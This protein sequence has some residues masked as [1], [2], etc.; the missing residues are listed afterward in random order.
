MKLKEIKPNGI[1]TVE[2]V[3][4][5]IDEKTNRNNG[6]FLNIGVSDGESQVIAKKWNEKA[7]T[8]VFKPGQAVLIEVKMEEYKGEPSYIIREIT[9][10][11][12]D[13]ALFI[14]G[15][16]LKSEYMYNFLY[17]TAGRCGVYAS[18]VK[19]I[20]AEN[21][22]KLMIWGA[23]KAIH[24]NIRGGLLYHTYRMTKMAAYT[25]SVYNKEPSMLKD[26]RD[27]NTELLVAG[28]ILHDIGKLCELDTNEFGVSEYTVKGTLMGH[29]FIGAELA[30]RVAREEGL[31]EEDIMLLQHLILSHH[32]KR[33]YEAVTVPAIPEALVLHHI[34]MIDS[35]M[36]QFEAQAEALKPGEMSNKV[37]GLDQRVYRPTWRVPQKKEENEEK[38]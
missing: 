32:G 10:S 35:Y 12:A 3:I 38:K 19:R 23:G 14:C 4:V 13:P 26:C 9:E 29:S 34:D 7:E 36:Y 15:A 30:G 6:T 16:P 21:K 33:E 2:C 37:F 17:K 11:S 5:T 25:T 18:T 28:T 27:I 1:G 31:D 20:L 8:F 22:E 24:H